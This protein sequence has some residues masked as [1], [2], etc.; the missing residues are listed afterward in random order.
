MRYSLIF[1][2][3]LIP[4]TLWALPC[5]NGGGIL[6]KGD[7]IEEVI[8]QC[9]EPTTKR[10]NTYIF[11]ML[12][13]WIYYIAH[14]YDSGFAQVIVS[15]KNGKVSKIHV[16]DYYYG[17]LICRRIVVQFGSA[18]TVQTSCNGAYDIG[19]TALCGAIFGIGDSTE[20]VEAICGLPATKSNLDINKMETTEL[21]YQGDDPQTIIFQNGKLSE[22]K[23]MR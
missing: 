6:Y 17:V 11:Y 10:S 12:Q 2:L 4:I 22:W 21:I 16:T 20:R 8:K 1:M 18:M 13:D 15:F 19:F 9:G 7:S 14:R 5:P 23:Q 3:L